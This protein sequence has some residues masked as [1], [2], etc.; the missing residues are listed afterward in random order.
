[1]S[2]FRFVLAG[3]GLAVAVPAIALASTGSPRAECCGGQP[4]CVEAAPCCTEGAACCAKQ[5]STITCLLTGDRIEESE[6][7]LCASK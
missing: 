2:K 3:L 7:P 5:D 6:G 4:C 1:M